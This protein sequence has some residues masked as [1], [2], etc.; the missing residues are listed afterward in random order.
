MIRRGRLSPASPAVRAANRAPLIPAAEPVPRVYRDFPRAPR[1]LST[2]GPIDAP[3]ARVPKLPVNHPRPAGVGVRPVEVN[4]LRDLGPRRKSAHRLSA[5]GR[6][7]LPDC[8]DVTRAGD[9]GS[10]AS[11]STGV[12]VK[13]CARLAAP[14]SRPEDFLR[15]QVRIEE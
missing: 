4:S 8:S 14:T 6:G 15:H 3:P 9:R 7:T 10:V 11:S 12:R 1:D 5:S 2:R 13:S